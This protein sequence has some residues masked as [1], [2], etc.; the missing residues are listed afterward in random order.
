SAEIGALRHRILPGLVLRPAVIGAAA[1]LVDEALALVGLD[2]LPAP[3]VTHDL[4]P[5]PGLV[6]A[7]VM[8]R[9]IETEPRRHHALERRPPDAHAGDRENV[10]RQAKDI[11][12]LACMVADLAD[13]AS[14]Q[15]DP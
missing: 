8:D 4:L 10:R 2:Q 15:S 7:V 12:D 3:V 9:H 1:E 6:I 5:E 13:R 14:A 11:G